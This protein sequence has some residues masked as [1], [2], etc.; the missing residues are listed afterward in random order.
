MTIKKRKPLGSIQ[1]S[2]LVV[3]TGLP[4]DTFN[5][6]KSKLEGDSR[7]RFA[8]YLGLPS[9]PNDLRD[10]YNK[11]TVRAVLQL[12]EGECSS[13]SPN[14][15]IV[16]YV[17][18]R[19]AQELL[20]ALGIVCFLAPLTQ[21]EETLTSDG[22]SIAWRHTKSSVKRVVYQTLRRA[23]KIT[24]ALKVE[25]TDRR[26]SAYSLPS[27]NFYYPD[28]QTTIRNTYLELISRES[29]FSGLSSKLLPTRFTRAQLPAKAFKSSQHTDRF[30]QD[31]RGRV[32]PPD[33]HHAP[34]RE[35]DESTQ[36]GGL[37]L[38][39]RQR[40]RFGVTVRDGN[41]HYDAQYELPR[42]LINEPMYCAIEGNVLVTGAHANV[43]VNDV[44]WVP[45]G[46]KEPAK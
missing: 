7:L 32:F 38:T 25:I 12:I 28:N 33:L 44:V 14:R 45:S 42:T 30:F 1:G 3:L 41:M 16:L 20:S 39:L 23:S 9:T 34:N 31:R 46:R 2:N 5:W 40:Y 18:S 19:D 6:I 21:D 11:K 4:R 35:N 24:D 37:S 15:I 27:Y 22:S 26:I 8:R 17:P 43:G 36:E 10:L 13:L 29:C